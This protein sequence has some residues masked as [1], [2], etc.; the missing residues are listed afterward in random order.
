MLKPSSLGESG[1]CKRISHDGQ[2][3]REV[4]LHRFA[5]LGCG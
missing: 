3:H 5:G 1:D 2:G 4:S